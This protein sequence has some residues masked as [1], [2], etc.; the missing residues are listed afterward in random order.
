MV[1]KGCPKCSSNFKDT[2]ETFIAKFDPNKTEWQNMVGIGY[3]I[4][5]IWF[6]KKSINKLIL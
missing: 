2:G 6:L 4:V 1:K 5:V 3:G